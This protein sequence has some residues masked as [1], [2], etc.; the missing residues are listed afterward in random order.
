MADYWVVGVSEYNVREAHPLTPASTTQGDC[1]FCTL[2]HS[3]ALC[4]TLLEE[5]NMKTMATQIDEEIPL[6]NITTAG[7]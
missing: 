5:Y 7:G 1:C 6:V 4:C 2:L 3:V